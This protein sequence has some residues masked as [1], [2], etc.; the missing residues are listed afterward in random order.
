MSNRMR[1]NRRS[2]PPPDMAGEPRGATGSAAVR[3]QQAP[4]QWATAGRRD[5]DLGIARHLPL[6]RL[7]PELHTRLVEEAV[8]VQPAGRQLPPVR[9][10][11]QLAVARDALTA[12]DIRPRLA[13]AAE[14][15]G[16]EPRHRDE[17]E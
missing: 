16:F 10:Q 2:S 9:V 8:A 4:G 14:P 5:T 15:H 11:R 7:A 3:Q 1:Q 6:P 13:P 17:A 12:F